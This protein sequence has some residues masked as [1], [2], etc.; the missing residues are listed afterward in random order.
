MKKINLLA[1]ALLATITFACKEDDTVNAT[2]GTFQVFFDNKVGS[3]DISLKEAGNSTF[4]FKTAS[5]ESF[6][7]SKLGYY[8][9]K[10]ILEGPNGEKFEDEISVSASEV[11]GYYQLLESDSKTQSIKLTNVPSGSY[12]K[13]TFTL[14]VDESGMKEGAIGGILDPAKGA[15]FW[16]WN[17]GYIGFLVEGNAEN[18]G[19]EYVDWGGGFETQEGTFAF[20]VGGWKDVQGSDKFVNNIKT[21]TLDFGTTVNVSEQLS[22]LAHI[23]VDV[24]KVMDKTSVDFSKTFSVHSPKLGKSFADVIPSI[25]TVHHVHQSTKNHD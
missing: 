2:P 17:A 18:S 1:I 21:I 6:N 25:F 13:I 19:Q 11:K 7:I 10:I 22:P 3:S 20:H 8:I 4:D 14:G 15:W 24:M 12:N 9:S 16:N 5:G 23:V